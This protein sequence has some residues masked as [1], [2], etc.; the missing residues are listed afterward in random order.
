M[1]KKRSAEMGTSKLGFKE[2][3]RAFDRRSA[4]A[5][6]LGSVA[7]AAAVGVAASTVEATPAVSEA[8]SV[9]EVHAD[10]LPLAT[11]IAIG[12]RFDG[13]GQMF[14]SMLQ[15][16]GRL[17]GDWA[18]PVPYPAQIAPLDQMTMIDSSNIGYG[19][20]RADYDAARAR[21]EDVVITGFSEGSDVAARLGRDIANENGGVLPPGVRVVV[22]GTPDSSTGV[23]NSVTGQ[24]IWPELELA[25]IPT[26]NRLPAG[27]EEHAS[28]NDVYANSA[29]QHMMGQLAMLTDINGGGHRVTAPWE[30]T[31]SWTDDQGVTHFR[32]D[33]GLHPWTQ[34]LAANGMALQSLDGLNEA[35]NGMF[36]INPGN[37][38]VAPAPDAI[39]T[40]EGFAKAIDQAAGTPGLFT[41]LALPLYLGAP[42][43]QIGLDIANYVPDIATQV[44]ADIQN[45]AA[46]MANVP[47]QPP[48]VNIPEGSPVMKSPSENLDHSIDALAAGLKGQTAGSADW[49][50]FVD[51]MA[52]GLKQMFDP[53][54]ATTTA[55]NS[56]SAIPASVQQN[57]FGAPS[58]DQSWGQTVDSIA[59]SLKGQGDASKDW[60]NFVDQVAGMLGGTAPAPAPAPATLAANT[61]PEAVS[62][63]AP[64]APAEAPAPVSAPAPAVS[65]PEAPVSAPAA[66]PVEAAPAPAPAPTPTQS[67]DQ[68]IDSIANSLK[69][70]GDTSK[71]WNNFVDQ[72]ATGIKNM[73]NPT[74]APAP[75]EA[76]APVATPAPAP[77][78]VAAPAAPVEAAPAPAPVEAPAPAPAPAPVIAAPA[79]APAPAPVEAPAPAPAPAP[80]LAPVAP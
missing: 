56:P 72:T 21:G 62:A 27:S 66:A 4:T 15:G 37:S 55:D 41:T 68:G 78:P 35:F 36:P 61:Q 45:G 43:V 2:R 76:P 54:P 5:V 51:Q 14:V 12:G 23:M 57:L 9:V 30:E 33:V 42:L 79:P 26:S 65:A 70:K 50:K 18:Q 10:Y 3:L 34:L 11:Q 60:N 39:A 28:Q 16:T 73:F 7:V 67:L 6:A 20:A 46:N 24:L 58:A 44:I 53:K 19:I 13:S 77:A 31:L 75:A 22:F 1:T 25:G 69:G 59:N 38:D 40:I 47:G 63:P 29:N 8:A 74:P 17:G 48:V 64:V 71:D 52:D 49:N 80:E 32:A